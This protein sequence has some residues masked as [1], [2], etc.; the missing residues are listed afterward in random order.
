MR[1]MPFYWRKAPPPLS[2]DLT[3]VAK[4]FH[5]VKVKFPLFVLHVSLQAT[6]K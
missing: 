1:S 4:S 2:S 3:P 5:K 6:T